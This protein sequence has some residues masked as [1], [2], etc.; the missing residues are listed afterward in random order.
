MPNF[1]ILETLKFQH[2]LGKNSD[3]L[4]LVEDAEPVFG[5]KEEG[6]PA[7]PQEYFLPKDIRRRQ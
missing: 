6:V 2:E 1:N 4:V 5:I 3:K 7:A